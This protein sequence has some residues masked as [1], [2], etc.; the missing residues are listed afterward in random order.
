MDIGGPVSTACR[1]SPCWR[2]GRGPGF[3]SCTS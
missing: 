3:P 2:V 1:P